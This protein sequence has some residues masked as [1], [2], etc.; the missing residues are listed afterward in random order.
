MEVIL[1]LWINVPSAK[2][3]SATILQQKKPVIVVAHSFGAF[4]AAQAVEYAAKNVKSLIV[5]G[6]YLVKNGDSCISLSKRVFSHLTIQHDTGYLVF[7]VDKDSLSLKQDQ[8]KEILYNDCSDEDTS[9]ALQNLCHEPAGIFKEYVHFTT[10]YYEKV[11]KAYLYCEKDNMMPL[12]LQTAMV[13]DVHCNAT[14]TMNTSH[15]PM[16]SDP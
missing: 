15:S 6:G 1:H 8:M 14:F 7:N 4:I 5:I 12:A 9:Y 2:K 10:G 3:L 11:P 16:I 13:N